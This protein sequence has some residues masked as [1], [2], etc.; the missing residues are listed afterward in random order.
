[1]SIKKIAAVV[2][3][4]WCAV[5]AS[6][7][8]IETALQQVADQFSATFKKGTTIAIVGISSDSTEM[9][10]FMLDDLSMRFVQ[11]RK[12]T[13]ANRANLDAIKTEMNFQ[14]SGEVSDESIQQL[15]AMVGANIVV[16]GKLIPIGS[17]FNLTMQAL[18][19]TSAAVVDMCRIRVDPNDTIKYLFSQSGVSWKKPSAI[20]S[21]YSG[22]VQLRMGVRVAGC[23]DATGVGFLLGVRNFNLFTLNDTFA[24]GFFEDLS[25]SLGDD[26]GINF[27]LGPAIEINIRDA[28]K[29]L[30]APGLLLGS[31]F[32]EG[33]EYEYYTNSPVG[34]ALDV[35]AKFRPTKRISPFVSMQYDMKGGHY[36]ITHNKDKSGDSVLHATNIAGGITFNFGK[37]H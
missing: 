16:H 11:A 20:G 19:V 14:L 26:W 30:I 2:C 31:E 36:R 4:A 27:V 1:M 35:T 17:S 34:F 15:G 24:V 33:E 13:V 3:A 37:G 25:G 28:V 32:S 10:D 5:A 6:A 7:V 18:D 8:D 23:E 29:L 21:R 9:S 12:V 22:D